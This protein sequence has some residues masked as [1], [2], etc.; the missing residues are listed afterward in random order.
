MLDH[1]EQILGNV[2]YH[3]ILLQNVSLSTLQTLLKDRNYYFIQRDLLW[4]HKF[5]GME[6][7]KERI[8]IFKILLDIDRCGLK[9]FIKKNLSQ[10]FMTKM[11]VEDFST[12]F[13]DKT[14]N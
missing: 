10:K 7:R 8:E 14:K 1:G 5:I 12:A 3:A 9:K 4:N 11:I 13:D 2:F 6:D